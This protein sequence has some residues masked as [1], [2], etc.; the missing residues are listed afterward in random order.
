MK[1]VNQTQYK[2]EVIEALKRAGKPIWLSGLHKIYK[3]P[4][5]TI[6]GSKDN[7]ASNALRNMIKLGQ[8]IELRPRYYK[9]NNNQKPRVKISLPNKNN[10]RRYFELELLERIEELE[11]KLSL[12]WYKRILL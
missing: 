9:A 12:P 4:Y 1:Q 6:H 5:A 8:I 2:K 3:L 7:P 10:P 11:R